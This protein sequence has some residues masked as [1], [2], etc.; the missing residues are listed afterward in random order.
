MQHV[1]VHR[2]ALM[3]AAVMAAAVILIA[4]CS[5]GRTGGSTGAS[6]PRPD[7]A[8]P[9]AEVQGS[10]EGDVVIRMG[11]ANTS[12]TTLREVATFEGRWQ[13]LNGAGEIR[14]EGHMHHLGAYPPEASRY[15]LTYEAQLERG[16]YTL[17]WGA[18]SIGSTALSFEVEVDGETVLVQG[19]TQEITDTFPPPGGYAE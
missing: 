13:L 3:I 5:P 15:P 2:L 16:A 14:A 9:I 10:A 11:V 12:H 4:G 19:V 7:L 6:E 18:P 1:K 8:T 17:L